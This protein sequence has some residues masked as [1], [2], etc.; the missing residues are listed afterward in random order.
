MCLVLSPLD[1]TKVRVEGVFG[2]V[3]SK[4]SEP[5]TSEPTLCEIPVTVTPSGQGN[6][7][8]CVRDGV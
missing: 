6:S 4:R 8:T 2:R 7:V 1:P 5:V 3:R